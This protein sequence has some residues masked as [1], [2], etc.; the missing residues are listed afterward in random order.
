M[1]LSAAESARGQGGTSVR[2]GQM[3]MSQS[4]LIVVRPM[5]YER[6]VSCLVGL[7]VMAEGRGQGGGV[8]G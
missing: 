2:E 4:H 6:R 3:Q 7:G 8:G 5:R 1:P